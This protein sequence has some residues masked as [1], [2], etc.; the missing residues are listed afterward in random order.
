MLL[1]FGA[2]TI[3]SG[4]AR[5]IVLEGDNDRGSVAVNPSGT[6]YI[7]GETAASLS[8]RHTATGGP[9]AQ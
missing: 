2:L 5:A 1:A 4:D 7:R 3:S 6:P 8:G 9:Q